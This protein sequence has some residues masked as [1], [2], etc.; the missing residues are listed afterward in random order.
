LLLL[1]WFL[2]FT[3]NP[4]QSDSSQ[5]KPLLQKGLIALQHGQLAEARSAL[6]NAS[7]IDPN[8]PYIFT[9]LAE[10]YFRLGETDKSLAAAAKA[11]QIGAKDPVVSH[12]LSIFYFHYAQALLQKQDFTRA[13]E[14]LTTALKADPRNAQLILALGVA[15]YGQRRFDEAIASFLE[16][17]QIDSTIEQ[18]YVFIAK[19]LDQAGPHLTEITKDYEAWNKQEPQN[20]NASFVLAKALLA[21]DPQSERAAE[22]LRHSIELDPNNWESHYELGVLLASK[23]DYKIAASELEHSIELNG[24]EAMPHYH[25][26]RVYDRLGESDRAQA[27]RAIHQ[28]LVGAH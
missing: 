14:V 12:A 10:T 22:L 9:S 11:E 17:I 13:A 26:A 20:P 1:L 15:R 3:L 4:N 7:R 5:A 21:R 25:L 23:H 16:V 8:N 2:L 6:E 28:K 19:M 27:E 24:K 18:P